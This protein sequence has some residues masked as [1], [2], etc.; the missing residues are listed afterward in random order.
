MFL[1]A[2]S[3]LFTKDAEV[4]AV[5]STGVLFVS[6]SQPIN[7]LA[8]IFDGLHYGVSDFPYAACSMMLVGAISSGFLLFAPRHLGLPGVW[9]GLTLFMGLRMMAGIIRLLSKKSP[10]WFLHCDTNEAKVIS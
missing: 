1:L 9:L 8:F 4:L 5:V 10:W 7:A 3:T 6:A 2:L